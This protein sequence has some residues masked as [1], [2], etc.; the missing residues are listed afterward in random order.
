MY[1]YSDMCTCI[2]TQT[3]ISCIGSSIQLTMILKNIWM[4]E[5]KGKHSSLSLF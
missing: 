4:K 3:Y 2:H 5:T 1:V